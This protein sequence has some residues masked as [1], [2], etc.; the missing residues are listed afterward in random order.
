MADRDAAPAE[1][2]ALELKDGFVRFWSTL[3]EATYRV[4]DGKILNRVLGMR[5]VELTTTGRRT[6]EPRPTMLTAPIVEAEK[7]VLVAS[8]GGDS[9]D[10]QWFRNVLACPEVTV[11]L[12]RLTRTM[13][14]RVAED[15]ERSDLWF[16]I[17][18][19]TP[20]YELYQNRTSR[21]L[22]VVVLEPLPTDPG[23]GGGT[24]A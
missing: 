24:S 3:H 7:I 10:P 11:T 13:R 14:A 15:P 1:R 23:S 21:Q 2:L 20:T 17:R 8:N 18:R 9:R 4:T 5:V 12:D 6:G 19:I 16:R 22:P